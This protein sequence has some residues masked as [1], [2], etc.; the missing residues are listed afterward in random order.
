MDDTRNI[1]IMK[2]IFRVLDYV[3]SRSNALLAAKYSISEP[4]FPEVQ[5]CCDLVFQEYSKRK[6]GRF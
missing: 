6:Y 2:R 5:K 3:S 4:E 1:A